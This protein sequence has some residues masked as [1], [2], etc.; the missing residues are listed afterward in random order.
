MFA[1]MLIVLLHMPLVVAS[2]MEDEVLELSTTVHFGGAAAFL[3]AL[4][5]ARWCRDACVLAWHLAPLLLEAL[6]PVGEFIVLCVVG[7]IIVPIVATAFVLMVALWMI[8]VLL[9]P[10]QGP[11]RRVGRSIGGVTWALFVLLL[12]ARTPLGGC[13]RLKELQ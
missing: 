10:P 6:K 13:M 3:L 12:A 1:P 8:F 11:S 7:S 2:F 9:R 4:G 5:A